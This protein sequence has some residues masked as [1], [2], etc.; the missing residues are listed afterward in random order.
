MT[1]DLW[2]LS[3]TAATVGFLHTITGPDHYLPFV[4]IG[5]ARHWSYARL[6]S[7][8][9]LC[10]IG[11]VLSSIV[12]ALVGVAAGIALSRLQAL[13]GLR[14]NWAT[15]AL[16]GFGIAY[17]LWG[18]RKAWRGETHSHLHRHAD[19]TVH[20]HPHHHLDSEHLHPHGENE[21][22][23]VWV[24]FAIFVLG[25]C[26]PLIPLAMVPAARHSWMGLLWI[27]LIFGLLTVGTM[28]ATA[29]FLYSGVRRIS[30]PWLE[31]YMHALA[32]LVIAL[33]GAAIVFLGL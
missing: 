4:M 8:T 7:V 12:I 6:A 18:L 28:T 31:R 1:G 16:M 29:L 24:L 2:V 14:G 30:L 20:S 21:S 17:M 33:S 13:E 23:T 27:A 5:R 9:V 25:P 26:E 19:G 22:I 15:Y 10:G 32:G 11:H 3:A